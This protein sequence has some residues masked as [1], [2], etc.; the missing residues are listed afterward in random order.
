MNIADSFLDCFF[1]QNSRSRKIAAV[2]VN[3]ILVASFLFFAL[4]ILLSA[5][6]AIQAGPDK[7]VR[8]GVILTLNASGCVAKGPDG[9]SLILPGPA[10]SGG[11]VIQRG[12]TFTAECFQ[13]TG[14]SQSND[15][16]MNGGLK[17][18]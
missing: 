13:S 8:N 17:N 7:G 12:T 11:V 10:A 5:K 2:L 9:K 1:S 15:R 14:E 16:V 6:E 3:A 4:I 18:E